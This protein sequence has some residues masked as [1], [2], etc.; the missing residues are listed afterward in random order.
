M[1]PVQRWAL[2]ANPN[3]GLVRRRGRSV[4]EPL[5]AECAARGIS[6]AIEWSG[7]PDEATALARAAAAAGAELVIAAGGDGTINKVAEGLLGS[8]AA[9][10]IVPGGTVNVLARALGIGTRPAAAFA[11]LLKGGPR[12]FWPGTI[13]GRLFLEMAGIG[14]DAAIVAAT[15]ARPGVKRRIGRTAYP[16]VAVAKF[17]ALPKPPIHGHPLEKPA[18]M[19]AIGRVPLYGGQFALMPDAEPFGRALGLFALHS[20]RRR[21]LLPFVAGLIGRGGR[22]PA[23]G[24]YTRAAGESFRF[25]A[26]HDCDYQVDGEWA[27]A[28]REFSIGVSESPLK[29][30]VAPRP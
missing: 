26:E 13:N 2:I 20:A 21:A 14:L 24:G 17:P 27:G 18:A 9:L 15:D 6:L 30:W 12:E 16:L 7:T 29:L 5:A 25:T 23:G 11:A 4:F 8:S 3:A 10:G 1:P 28:A 22:L 19:V